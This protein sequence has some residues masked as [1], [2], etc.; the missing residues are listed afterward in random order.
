MKQQGIIRKLREGEFPFIY[1]DLK[2]IIKDIS[3]GESYAITEK[4]LLSTGCTEGDL[5]EYTTD[6][7]GGLVFCGVICPVFLN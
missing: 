5:I 7:G 1:S 4:V 2:Y 3:S 6:Q